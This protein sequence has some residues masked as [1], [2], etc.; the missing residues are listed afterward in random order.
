MHSMD[1]T[2]QLLSSF[3]FKSLI[4]AKLKII[5][6][7]IILKT[8]LNTRTISHFTHLIDK[9]MNYLI[10]SFSIKVRSVL[11]YKFMPRTF[12][13]N[14]TKTCFFLQSSLTHETSHSAGITPSHS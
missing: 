6:F 14:A 4:K 11:S 3:D 7:F 1:Y 5:Q 2:N 13:F 9:S 10:Y 8:Y 12:H